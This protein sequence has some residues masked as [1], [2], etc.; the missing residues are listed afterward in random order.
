[1]SKID[2]AS[3][4]LR[5]MDEL[6]EGDS[7]IHELHPLT[8]LAITLVYVITT[9][10]FGKYQLDRLLIMIIYPA[11]MFSMSGT[12]VSTCFRKLGVVLPLVCCV[13]LFNPFFDRVPMMQVGNLMIT[14]GVISMLTLMLKGVLCLMASFLLA[15]TT[16][17]DSLCLAL[18][19][20][21]VPGILVTLILL[22]FRYISLMVEEVGI[23]NDAY[24]LRAPGEKGVR[25][26]AWG[27]FLGQLLLRSVDRAQELY[28]GMQL[29]GFKGEFYYADTKKAGAKDLI[30]LLVMILLIIGLRMYDVASLVGGLVMGGRG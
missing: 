30:F 21:H 10:S 27:S 24:R 26:K 23:M 5:E 4:E 17:I 12:K 20:I 3:Y 2:K 9:V 13:G 25:Y 14:G 8:K 18:R 1:M 28:A 29:R 6:A 7:L 11:F 15:A 19:K 22:T 16:S